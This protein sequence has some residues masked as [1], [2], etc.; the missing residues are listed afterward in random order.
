MELHPRFK[1][2]PNLIAISIAMVLFTFFM[3]VAKSSP[4]VFE[5]DILIEKSVNKMESLLGNGATDRIQRTKRA[6]VAQR[7]RLWDSGIIPYYI[8]ENAGYDFIQKARERACRAK[9]QRTQELYSF[10]SFYKMWMLFVR[11]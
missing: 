9:C 11:W 1:F 3:A 10:H 8:D 6:A 5:G 2:E 7:F 4:I